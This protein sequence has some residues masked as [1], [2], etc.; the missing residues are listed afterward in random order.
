V[1]GS[2]SRYL[3]KACRQS[4]SINH[5]TTVPLLWIP[6]IDGVPFRK[7]GN[8]NGLGGAQAYNRVTTELKQLP[9]NT[10]LTKTLCDPRRFSRI[11]IMD[12]KYVKVKGYNAKIPFLYGIDYLTHDIPFGE[13]YASEDELAFSQ[14]F[15]KLK[16]LDYTPR[17]VVAD[18]RAGLKQA[19]HKV[20]PYAKLQL[21]QNHYL[22][23]IRKLL[24]VRTETRYQYFF[25]S[26]KLHVFKRGTNEQRITQGLVH[27]MKNHAK[28]NKL[29][30]DILLTIHDRQDLL[31]NYLQV[32][33]CP[34]NT[35]LIELYNSHLNGRLK[36][37][38]GFQSLASAKLWLNAYLIRRRTKQLT[39]CK[40]KF[41]YLNKH[42]SLELTIKKQATWPDI[43]TKL[44]IIQTNYFEKIPSES[45]K[46]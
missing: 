10:E 29:L 11:L 27:V 40:Q 45:T 24:K 26:L 6:H 4:F 15:S 35:N 25:E 38:K 33:D 34:N 13:I 30:I 31:F 41:K 18:D 3:C 2:S 22:E 8:E 19:L 12:G 37:I 9:S 20:F 32:T 21:C 16:E 36:T 46:Y 44:G 42:A 43:L 14:F 7:L 28:Q 5:G 17:I 39:D 1:Q 23:N